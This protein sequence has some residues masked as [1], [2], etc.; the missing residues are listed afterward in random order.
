MVMV[1]H[2]CVWRMYRAR[3]LKKPDA[4]G[5]GDKSK[6]DTKKDNKKDIRKENKKDA[7]L[8]QAPVKRVPLVVRVEERLTPEELARRVAE[9]A[10]H[11]AGKKALQPK[12]VRWMFNCHTPT[13][14]TI[15]HSKYAKYHTPYIMHLTL[16][17]IPHTHTRCYVSGSPSYA[18]LTTSVVQRNCPSSCATAVRLSRSV[19]TWTSIWRGGV[20]EG[21]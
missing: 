15:C 16:Y 12:E 18:P 1:T 21:R 3:W 7:N 19:V 6:K 10:I 2:K 9:L 14:V 13:S 4:P 11:K 20:E 8:S 17:T 5:A